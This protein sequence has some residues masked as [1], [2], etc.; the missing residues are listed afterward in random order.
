MK[1][2]E[3]DYPKLMEKMPNIYHS[4]EESKKTNNGAIVLSEDILKELID[5]DLARWVE[6]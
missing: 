5:A 3:I 1:E 2:I 4:I 6:K